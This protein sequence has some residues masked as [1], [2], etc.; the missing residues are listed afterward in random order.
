MTTE[1]QSAAESRINEIVERCRDLHV[2]TDLEA[3]RR[4]KEG[5]PDAR[6]SALCR[7]RSRW[8]PYH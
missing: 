1:S 4:W 3:V 6:P 2:D 8:S 5:R 7:C